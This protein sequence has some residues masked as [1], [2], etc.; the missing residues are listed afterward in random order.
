MNNAA[1]AGASRQK[2]PFLDLKA[3]F[4]CFRRE[5]LDAVTRVVESQHFILGPE[6][7]ALEKELSVVTGC[8]Y[9]IGCASGTDALVLALLALEIG[10]AD[11]VITTPFTFIAT[12]GSIARAEA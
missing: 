3:Q 2:M 6:V 10:R 4:V 9:C 5:I 11:E 12:A 7:E 1:S 8:K